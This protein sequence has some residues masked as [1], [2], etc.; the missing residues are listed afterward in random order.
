MAKPSGHRP[1]LS[2]LSPREELRSANNE[3]ELGIGSP[4]PLGRLLVRGEAG[5]DIVSEL[6]PRTSEPVIDKPGRSAFNYTDFELLL[7]NKSVN[8]LIIAGVTTDVCVS[9]TIRDAS[10]RGYD[11]LLIDDGCA[12]SD[13]PQTKHTCDT[14]KSE[15]GIFGAV[16][17]LQYIMSLIKHEFDDG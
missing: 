3:A 9:S 16:T 6:Y 13:P 17:S 1:D 7:K 10:D 12:S 14:V 11:C 15:G 4:G 2:T 5:H 8:N